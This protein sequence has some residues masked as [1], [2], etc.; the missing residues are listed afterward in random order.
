MMLTCPR[1]FSMGKTTIVL[2]PV[3]Q[4]VCEPTEP[5][6]LRDVLGALDPVLAALGLRLK[7]GS[8]VTLHRMCVNRATLYAALQLGGLPAL[9][10]EWQSVSH[11]I[12]GRLRD[13]WRTADKDSAWAAWLTELRRL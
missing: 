11:L 2:G 13:E 8:R 9:R 3:P 10:S 12:Q 1:V 7:E 6:C 4:D 5:L